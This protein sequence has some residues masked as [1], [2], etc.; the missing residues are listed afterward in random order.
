MS[1]PGNNAAAQIKSYVE[2]IEHLEAEKK[3]IAEDIREIYA[4]AK[5]NS[6][7]PKALRAAVRFLK[8]DKAEREAFQHTLDQYLLALGVL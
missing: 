5:N 3:G 7:D 8:Q 2:R 4:E 6:F 1:A